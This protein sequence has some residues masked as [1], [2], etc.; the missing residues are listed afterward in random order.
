[1]QISHLVT[2]FNRADQFERSLRRLA[3]LTKPDE[4]VV[5]DDGG[6]DHTH[7]VVPNLCREMGL[8]LNYIK[9]TKPAGIGYDISSIPRNIGIKACQHDWILVSEPEILFVT[10]VIARFKALAE[11][12]PNHV[13]SAGHIYFTNPFTEIDAAIYQ[14]PEACLRERWDVKKFPM[15]PEDQFNPDG[16]RVNYTPATVTDAHNMTAT[17]CVL[18]NKQWL[19]D[20]GG[21]DEDMSLTRGG[22]G[23][24]WEDTDL[25]TRLRIRGYNQVI[26]DESIVIHQWHTRPPG[27]IAD[28]WK[29]NEAIFMSRRYSVDGVEDRN[30]PNLVAN[31]G[32]EWGV[33]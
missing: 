31:Q 6:T 13:I 14:Q 12:H 28:G 29:P 18:Y 11:Q 33:L 19:L 21:W 32:R 25:L 8:P 22:G 10:D 15:H 16:T 2:T 26:D 24:A 3:L 20:I 7:E 30:N 23:Y 27:P 5:V 1:M 4:M 17:F 9:R